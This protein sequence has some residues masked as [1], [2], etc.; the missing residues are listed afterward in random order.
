MENWSLKTI[1]MTTKP[2]T[3]GDVE[4]PLEKIEEGVLGVD[5]T[6]GEFEQKIAYF[7]APEKYLGNQI[8]SYGGL[9]KF[10]ILYTTNLYGSAV[11]GP[12][13]VLY[14]RDT[15]LYYFSLEQPA[16]NTVFPNSVEL[17]EQNFILANGLPTTREQIMQ[18]LQDLD[19]VYIRATYWDT[20]V[21]TR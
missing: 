10:S 11:T 1:N 8:K 6:A 4:S 5:L 14:G 15:Y 20:S 12:D 13:V 21:T 17:N 2:V 18:V 3:V 7:V 19:G 9:L 16:S